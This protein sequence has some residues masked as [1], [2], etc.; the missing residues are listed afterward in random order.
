M[1]NYLNHQNLL[2]QNNFL[3]GNTFWPVTA[4][5]ET[6]E[7]RKEVPLNTVTQI[8]CQE[9]CLNGGDDCVGVSCS[10]NSCN[11][12]CYLCSSQ[13]I[14][15]G[16]TDDVFIKRPGNFQFNHWKLTADL[17]ISNRLLQNSLNYNIFISLTAFCKDDLDCPIGEPICH[18][19]GFCCGNK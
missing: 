1:R 16:A 14:I 8:T 12:E 6:C 4:Y 11:D 19:D 2:I 18:P 3:S 10:S 5:N 15:D 9:A 7:D 13:S 17:I